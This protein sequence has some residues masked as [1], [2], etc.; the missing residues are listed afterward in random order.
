MLTSLI[1]AHKELEKELER[2][3]SDDGATPVIEAID[4]KMTD[5]DN[6]IRLAVPADHNEAKAK[7]DF[8]LSRIA[9]VGGAVVSKRDIDSIAELF[10]RQLGY[11]T[12]TESNEETPANSRIASTSKS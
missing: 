8:F 1:Q 5:L 7:L 6:S 11:A 3:I 10:D 4:K 9:I 2:A 12:E